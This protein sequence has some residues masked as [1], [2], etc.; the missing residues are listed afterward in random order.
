MS[1]NSELTV[2]IKRLNEDIEDLIYTR[3]RVNKELME[4]HE[5]IRIIQEGIDNY[6]KE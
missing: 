2:L 5:I 4:K 6:I 3:E 1:D